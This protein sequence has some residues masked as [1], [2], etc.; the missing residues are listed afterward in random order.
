MIENMIV[1][2]A[3]LPNYILVVRKFRSK[4]VSAENF[5]E[6]QDAW[7]KMEC[8]NINQQNYLMV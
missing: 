1:L 5:Q 8:N 3:L 2:C 7:P 4:F 6:V